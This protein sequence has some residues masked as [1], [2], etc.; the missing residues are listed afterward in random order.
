MPDKNDTYHAESFVMSIAYDENNELDALLVIGDKNGN[1]I[2]AV[3]GIEAKTL[4][5]NVKNACMRSQK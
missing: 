3:K 5:D 2:G 4:F 1:V